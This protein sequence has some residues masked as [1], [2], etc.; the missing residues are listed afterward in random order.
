M[1]DGYHMP[2]YYL[3]NARQVPSFPGI[4]NPLTV[5]AFC[6]G[7]KVSLVALTGLGFASQDQTSLEHTESL[8]FLV[9]SAQSPSLA[10]VTVP[11]FF[12]L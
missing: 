9:L 2:A 3:W 4:L 1:E 8:R 5:M 10:P 6:L 12:S 11:T 7:D